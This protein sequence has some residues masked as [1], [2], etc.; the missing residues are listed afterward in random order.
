M[1][2]LPS[3]YSACKSLNHKLSINHKISHDTNLH[4]IKQKTCTHALPLSCCRATSD[5]LPLCLYFVD[6]QASIQC[7]TDFLITSLKASSIC[8]RH[9]PITAMLGKRLP[10]KSVWGMRWQVE[11]S[12]PRRIISGLKT[13][14]NLSPSYSARKSSNH[15]FSASYKI[16][17]LTQIHIKQ[18]IHTQTAN[19]HWIHGP[20]HQFINT[21]F[22][23]CFC[24]SPAAPKHS[25]VQIPQSFH[26][27]DGQT[28]HWNASVTFNIWLQYIH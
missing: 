24:F 21:R 14:F 3:I 1:F 15:K 5:R 10:E 2:N 26:Q 23:V 22:K 8:G 27:C 28:V 6:H 13:N 7:H 25:S 16:K 11:P 12:Q 19:T 17:V 9:F 20:I 4:K 18:N